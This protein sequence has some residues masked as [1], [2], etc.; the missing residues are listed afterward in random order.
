MP[1]VAALLRSPEPLVSAAVGELCA[2]GL[3]WRGRAGYPDAGLAVRPPHRGDEHV[4]SGRGDRRAD[5]CRR[6]AAVQAL[7]GGTAGLRKPE[8]IARLAELMADPDTVA[9]VVAALPSRA[10]ERFDLLWRGYSFYP[11]SPKSGHSDAPLVRAGLLV[12]VFGHA[13][14]SREVAVAAWLGERK[15]TLTGPPELSAGVRTVVPDAARPAR[16]S[17]LH[18]LTALLDEARVAGSRR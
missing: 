16:R 17:P 18:G 9:Q 5:L 14:F 10:R 4:P 6:V 13:E 8:L 1:W 7:G 12:Q 3:A 15:V 11:W 2:R